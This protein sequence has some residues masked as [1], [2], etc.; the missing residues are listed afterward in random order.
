MGTYWTNFA[1]TGDPNG[2]GLAKWPR[3]DAQDGFEVMHLAAKPHAEKDVQ[4]AQYELLDK[5]SLPS[6]SGT[7][8]TT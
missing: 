5:L 1:K 7:R 6:R 3:Y 2:A 8:A 4:R